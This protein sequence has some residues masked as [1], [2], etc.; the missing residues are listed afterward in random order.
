MKFALLITASPGQENAW[1]ALR[2]CEAALAQGHSVPRVFF[3][4]EGVLTA[5]ALQCPPQDDIALL[6]GWQAL[7]TR[8]V[9]L[10]VCVAAALKRGV[11]DADNAQRM[12]QG[13]P[14]LAEGFAI[15][16]LG[17]LVE[18]MLEADRFVSF[19]G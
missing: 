17:Q 13:P 8:G 3:Y 10:V 19:P 4:G 14:N 15:S 11:L 12:E 1:H 6:A 2:F 18:A 7:S 5:N 16:G 9:E